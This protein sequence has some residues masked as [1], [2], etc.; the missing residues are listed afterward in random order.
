MQQLTVSRVLFSSEQTY[1][2]AIIGNYFGGIMI[3]MTNEARTI[4][5][6]NNVRYKTHTGRSNTPYPKIARATLRA[7]IAEMSVAILII[8]ACI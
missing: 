8:I 5:L 6:A 4:T 2:F 3:S 1:I 7:I